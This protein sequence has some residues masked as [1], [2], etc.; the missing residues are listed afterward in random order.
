MLFDNPTTPSSKSYNNLTTN[1]LVQLLT[2][3]G[4]PI[5]ADMRGGWFL[6]TLATVVPDSADDQGTVVV[7]LSGTGFVYGATVQLVGSP[8]INATS[9]EWVGH[10]LM[11]ATF[12]LTGAIPGLYDVVINNPGGGSVVDPDRFKITG[13]TVAVAFHAF[14]VSGLAGGI[15]LDW[16]ATS[17]IG[18]EGFN[19]YRSPAGTATFVKLNTSGVLPA[20]QARYID[21]TAEPGRRY[22]Y[23]IGAVDRD[24]EILS[25][26]TSGERPLMEARLNQNVPNPFNPVTTISFF[27]PDSRAAR[28]AIYDTQGRLVRVLFRGVASMGENRFEWDG[29]NGQGQL[30]GSGIYFYKLTAGDYRQTRK[31]LLLK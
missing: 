14:E 21:S 9:V 24:G 13:S 26:P 28:L 10:A 12:D 25:V 23:R 2:G 7:T 27:S 22:T 4:D 30:V 16:R 6:P 20:E 18:I 29:K 15:A 5:T 8:V 11:N 31:M 1:V 3:N 19:I 17:D